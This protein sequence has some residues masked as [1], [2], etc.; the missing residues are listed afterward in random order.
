MSSTA[1]SIYRPSVFKMQR[2]FLQIA[3]LLLLCSDG[4][5]QQ[6]FPNLT[7]SQDERSNAFTVSWYSQ[8]LKALEEPSLWE[9]RATSEGETYRFLWLRTFHNPI[10][11]RLTVNQDGSGVVTVKVTDGAGGYEPGKLIENQSRQLSKD[12]V[13]WFL[14]AIEEQKYWSLP[15]SGGGSGLDGAGWILEAVRAHKYKVVDRWSPERGPIRTLGVMM[16]FDLGQLH[17]PLK[18]IY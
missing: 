2:S 11:V 15:T 18:D 5:C 7:F 16:F 13:Q 6:Y 9:S 1:L 12:H 17:V 10:A 3:C 8:A 14:E 4:A